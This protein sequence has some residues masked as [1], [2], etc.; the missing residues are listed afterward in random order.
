[1]DMPYGNRVQGDFITLWK[2]ATLVSFAVADSIVF[3][4]PY[5]PED[6]NYKAPGSRNITNH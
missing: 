4:T 1:M 2:W 5:S 3:S 6:M